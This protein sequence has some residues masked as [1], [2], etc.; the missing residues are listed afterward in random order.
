MITAISLSPPDSTPFGQRVRAAFD[1]FVDAYDKSDDEVVGFVLDLTAQK[2]LES[3][4]A[5]L[6]DSRE[7]LRLRDLFNSIASHELKTPLTTLR[8][9]ADSMAHLLGRGPVSPERIL[10]KVQTIR[11]QIGRL[12][13][14]GRLV[15]ERGHDCPGY[16]RCYCCC[17]TGG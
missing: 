11:G 5:Q 14:R 9:Q 16:G 6:Q 2:H 4:R 10:S 1:H 12:G 13:R 8:L 3:Q 15:R 7:A 17:R